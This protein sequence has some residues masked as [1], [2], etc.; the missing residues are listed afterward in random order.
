MSKGQKNYLEV[1]GANRGQVGLYGAFFAACGRVS[2]SVRTSFLSNGSE[3]FRLAVCVLGAAESC[4]SA[5]T[6]QNQRNG[7]PDSLCCC[8]DFIVPNVDVTHL[9]SHL[10]VTKEPRHGL[11][12]DHL[13]EGLG[14]GA[15]PGIMQ[16]DAGEASQFPNP[17]PQQQVISQKPLRIDR[18]RKNEMAGHAPS[19]C[20]DG[21]GVRAQVLRPVLRGDP[22]RVSI[23][24]GPSQIL[25]LALPATDQEQQ[26]HGG[27]QN[28]AVS[29]WS[30]LLSRR[31]S[32][33]D[34]SYLSVPDPAVGRAGCFLSD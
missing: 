11:Q 20:D 29:S 3:G 26:F 12:Q 2:S 25:G 30:T 9:H 15:V 8:D 5:G 4:R 7:F 18:K 23:D 34:R 13:H 32:S 19:P 28:S 1:G 24:L 31:I 33:Q 14:S 22:G 17:V 6:V 27:G 21:T 10:A 16:P